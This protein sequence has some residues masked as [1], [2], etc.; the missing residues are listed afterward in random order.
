MHSSI[1]RAHGVE[2][3]ARAEVAAVDGAPLQTPPGGQAVPGAQRE[4]PVLHDRG[5]LQAALAAVW[6]YAVCSS[7]HLEISCMHEGSLL[8]RK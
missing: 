7:G 3:W 2:Q 5:G 8:N 4:R 6:R 1:R